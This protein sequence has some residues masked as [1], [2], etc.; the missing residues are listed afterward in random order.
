MDEVRNAAVQSQHR[1][2]G[3]TK[4]VKELSQQTGQGK[5]MI[6]WIWQGAGEEMLDGT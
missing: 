1:K 6:S 3:K 2:L 5:H 4:L